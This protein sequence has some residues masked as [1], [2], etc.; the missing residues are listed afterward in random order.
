MSKA[1]AASFAASVAILGGAITFIHREPVTACEDLIKATLLS[2]GSYQRVEVRRPHPSPGMVEIEI[3]YDAKNGF[4]TPLRQEWRCTY[5]RA[6]FRADTRFPVNSGPTLAQLT[7]DI[8][9]G[10]PDA[11]RSGL[12][13]THAP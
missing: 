13:A 5:Q 1:L 6:G 11:D 7:R 3:T 9:S 12:S 4:G 8:R 2:P 10:L